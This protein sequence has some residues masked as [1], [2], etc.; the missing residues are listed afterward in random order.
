[1]LSK[2][3]R[4]D[5]VREEVQCIEDADALPFPARHLTPYKKYYSAASIAPPTT[6]VMTSFG[7]P[8]RC[9]FCNTSGIQR[10]VTKSPL[11][12]VD[13]LEGCVSMGIR[14]FSILDENFTVHHGRVMQIAEEILRRR[15]S[16][17]WSFK[18]RVDLVDR[19]LLRMVRRAGCCSIHFGV[20]SGDPDIL[21]FIRKD[22]TPDQVR[23]TFRLAR[24]EGLETTAAFMIGFPGETRAQIEKTIDFAL[25][26]DPN[27]AQ[28]A[29]AIPLP[30]TELYHMA[31]ERGLFTKDYWQEFAEHPVRD[32]RPPGWYEAFSEQE[33]E[34]LLDQSYRRFYVRPR[35]IWRRIRALHNLAELKRNIR[36]GARILL[37]R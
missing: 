11:R 9:I 1:M 16:I 26:I 18:S 13:E 2:D 12:V 5:G 35:Y 10:M 37:R 36:I 33:M 17:V 3:D 31:F 27:Y 28:F 20:E 15:L 25:E 19:E 4:V 24:Q 30:G 21:T 8:F 22:I 29:I 34:D 23:Q 7:C 32:F 6:V 14:E